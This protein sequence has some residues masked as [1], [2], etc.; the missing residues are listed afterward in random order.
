MV[1][2]RNP[3]DRFVTGPWFR[4]PGVWGDGEGHALSDDDRAALAQFAR[5]VRFAKGETIYRDGAAAESVFN[6]TSGM[7]KA[8][9][10]GRGEAHITCFLF[11][12][13]LFGLALEGRYVNTVVAVTPLTAYR[14]P[15]SRIES[16]IYR[17]P[18]FD[19]VAICKLCHELREAQRHGVLLSRK[20]A[21]AR[22]AMFLQIM[23]AHQTLQ[24]HQGVQAHQGAGEAVGLPMSRGDIAA[25]TG[26]TPEAVTRALQ[27][28]ARGG[29]IDLPDLRHVTIRDPALLAGATAEA[30][31]R[32]K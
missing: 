5:I 16:R 25:Y 10:D 18:D 21:T 13:D 2:R 23:Q 22:M 20:S 24:A 31:P 12:G 1:R 6:I 15:V 19:Y 27:A 3:L 29:A 9:A 4:A 30:K 26:L 32:E 8:Y 28:L 11:P 17:R 7:A 14:L